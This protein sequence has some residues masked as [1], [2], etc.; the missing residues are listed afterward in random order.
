MGMYSV[1]SGNTKEA[2]VAGER[3]L[4][5]RSQRGDHKEWEGLDST[6]P[7]GLLFKDLG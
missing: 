5:K 6:G 1:H 4:G 7:P 3:E 2:R